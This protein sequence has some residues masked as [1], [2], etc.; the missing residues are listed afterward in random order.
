MARLFHYHYWTPRVEEMER[1]YLACDFKL[2]Q[3]VGRVPGAEWRR[4]DMCNWAEL[5]KRNVMLRIIEMVMGEVNVTFGMGKQDLFDHVGFQVDEDG[6]LAICK[7]AVLKGWPVERNERR[8][9]ITTP[10]TFRVELMLQP[11]IEEPS[12]CRI[13]SL[14]MAVHGD[15]APVGELAQLLDIPMFTQPDSLRLSDGEWEWIIHSGEKTRVEE[16]RLAT[17]SASVSVTDPVGVRLLLG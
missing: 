3:R 11:V 9:F 12:N 2:N 5:R 8:T 16:V 10:W 15:L 6:M 7:R 1:C 17:P 13:R 14:T 4:W